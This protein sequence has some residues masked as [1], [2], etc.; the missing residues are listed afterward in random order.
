MAEKD[1]KLSKSNPA[2]KSRRWRVHTAW[3]VVVLIAA[4]LGWVSA[5]QVLAPPTPPP[6]ATPVATYTV[7][8]G[9][10]GVTTPTRA[11]VSFPEDRKI[12]SGASGTVTGLNVDGAP[13]VDAGSVLLEIDTRP[14]VVALGE[15][16]AFRDL[17]FGVRGDDVAQL[18]TFLGLAAGDLFD[19]ATQRAVSAWQRSLGVAPDGFVRQGDL[20]FLPRLPAS[21]RLED[22]IAVGAR[23]DAGQAV[24][25]VLEQT[26]QIQ[27]AADSAG[28]FAGGMKVSV[29]LL[30][31]ELAGQLGAP[32][33]TS[34]GTSVFPVV[35]V[36]GSSLCESSCGRELLES[37]VI[38]VPVQV[39][40]ID[41]TAG[42]VVPDSAIASLP[43][44]SL[45]V[46]LLSGDWKS[47]TV[48]T[49]GS[50]TSVV[51]GV[52]AGDEI[53]LFADSNE[54]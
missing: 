36:E 46:Q 1:A 48:V 21:V 54:Q 7:Q 35:D 49:Q 8:E 40:L 39:Q 34:E 30:G 23:V 45:G 33:Q 31:T 38:E 42:L 19:R 6:A 12:Y 3:I 50:G 51:E 41:V 27:V 43:D 5:S 24:I 10:V 2:T 28:Q 52:A 4:T 53:R 17:S 9:E 47:I 29:E 32:V 11:S 14:I 37:G 13:S 26:A 44:G 22:G 15:T 20:A 16:P 25:S 18:R